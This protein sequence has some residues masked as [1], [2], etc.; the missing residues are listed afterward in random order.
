MHQPP[1]AFWRVEDEAHLTV[2][3]SKVANVVV[4]P[5]VLYS[6]SVEDFATVG[7]LT[8]PWYGIGSKVNDVARPL[9]TCNLMWIRGVSLEL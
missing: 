5:I 2:L 3:G 7:C 8:W 1:E 9:C 4:E 6:T